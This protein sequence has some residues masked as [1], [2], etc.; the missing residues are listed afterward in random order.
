MS[1][2]DVFYEVFNMLQ[3]QGV[4]K[5]RLG[6]LELEFVFSRVHSFKGYSFDDKTINLLWCS[7]LRGQGAA[8]AGAS[9]H[10]HTDPPIL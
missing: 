7:Y 6:N 4:S 9:A 2:T 10:P 5:R 3:K 8:C 1:L